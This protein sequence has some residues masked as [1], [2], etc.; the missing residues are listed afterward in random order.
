MTIQLNFWLFNSTFW[1]SNWIFD[2]LIR[3]LNQLIAFFDYFIAFLDYLNLFF[4]QFNLTPY[5][6][7]DGNGPIELIVLFVWR[8]I[9]TALNEWTFLPSH[10]L[11]TYRP[12]STAKS[13]YNQT[14]PFQ[15]LDRYVNKYFKKSIKIN[16]DRCNSIWHKFS[17]VYRHI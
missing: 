5:P 6:S 12:T 15:R 4:W 10:W 11:S 13:F 2:K 8:H 3:F 9:F 1:L 7:H 16:N 14:I 17:K